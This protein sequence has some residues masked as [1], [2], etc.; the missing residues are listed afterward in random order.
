MKV[1]TLLLFAAL[2]SAA[3]NPESKPEPGTLV[4]AERSENVVFTV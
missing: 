2:A 1:P 4:Y 3:P